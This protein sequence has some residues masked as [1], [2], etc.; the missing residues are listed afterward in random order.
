MFAEQCGYDE[1]GKIDGCV[2][3]NDDSAAM[4][5]KCRGDCKVES[6]TCT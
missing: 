4:E 3:K 2:D 6:E 5:E 1:D